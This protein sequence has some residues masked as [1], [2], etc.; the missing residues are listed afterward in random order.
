[1]HVLAQYSKEN[2]AS[3]FEVFRQTMPNYPF[4][5]YDVDENTGNV[6]LPQRGYSLARFF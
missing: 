2:A 4:D 5:A 3:I 6:L 1:M